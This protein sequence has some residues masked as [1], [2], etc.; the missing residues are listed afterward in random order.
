ME[1]VRIDGSGL[2][3]GP[4]FVRLVGEGMSATRKVVLLK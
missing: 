4:Y 2:S 1:E 3:S